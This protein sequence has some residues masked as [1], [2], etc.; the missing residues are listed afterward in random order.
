VAAFDL[1][2]DELRAYLPERDEPPDFDAFW[3]QTLDATRAQPL[4]LAVEPVDA[5]LRSFETFD[6]TFTGFGGTRIKGWLIL[7]SA[8]SGHLPCVVEY[9]GYGGGRGLLV[10]RLLWASA[11]F[12]HFVMDNRGQGSDGP[13]GATADEN[14][15][16]M[17]PHYPGFMTLGIHDPS[18]HYYRRLFTDAVR[19]LDAVRT[20]P[21]VDPSRL[22]AYGR[23]Q[24]GGIALAVAGLVP[25]LPLLLCDV[26]FLCHYRRA[27]QLVDTMPYA[28]IGQYLKIH[29]GQVARVFRTLGY[30]DGVN[31]APRARARAVFSVGLMDDVCPPST[32]FAAFN[33]YAGPK[34]MRVWEFNVHEGGGPFQL[35]HQVR[36][37]HEAWDGRKAS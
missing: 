5:G 30:V 25:D 29:R 27:T 22:A 37:L 13:P 12:A 24:G 4:A 18:A 7:P 31:F 2:L 16:A 36:L 3:T 9:I 10:E 20:L 8:R 6:V 35:E 32:V 21:Q 23:S 17:S 11:G 1:P 26:P 15:D 28:E 19:A 33:H 34:D 14:A